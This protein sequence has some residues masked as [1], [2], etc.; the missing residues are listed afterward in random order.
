VLP[1]PTA[2]ELVDRRNATAQADVM[3]A[4]IREYLDSNI[5]GVGL[6]DAWKMFRIATKN[7]KQKAKNMVE[8]VSSPNDQNDADWRED[9][10]SK[11]AVLAIMEEIADFHE[12]FANLCH[13]RDPNA[14]TRYAIILG[15]MILVSMFA[16]AKYVVKGT[17]AVGGIVFWFVPNIWL[18][19]PLEHRSRIPPPLADVPTDAEYAMG[20]ISQRVDRGEQVLPPE[21]RKKDKKSRGNVNVGTTKS[22]YSLSPSTTF[23]KSSAT[24]DS[25]A[26]DDS[27]LVDS[28]ADKGKMKK[29]KDKVKGVVFADQAKR[30]DSLDENGEPL[31]EQTFPAKYHATMGMIS[32]TPTTLLFYPMMSSNAKVVIPLSSI[33]GVKKAGRMGGLRIKYVVPVDGLTSSPRQ[34]IDNAS[35]LTNGD[36][37]TNG[38]AANGAP[39]EKEEKFGWISQRDEVFAKLVGWGGRRWVK[40]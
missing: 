15:I 3:G 2:Q 20:I 35:L 4:Q 1:Y 29:F 16:P 9:E 18:A 33:R 19:L 26:D 22:T 6:K 25:Q 21:L 28:N 13:W 10:N 23:N 7:K 27:I 36:A 31:P 38:I 40:M 14:S 12:R 8:D 37:S 32:L 17:Y 11:R 39:L 5:S 24:L 30:Q 34:S